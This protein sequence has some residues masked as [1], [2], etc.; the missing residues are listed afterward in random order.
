MIPSRENFYARNSNFPDGPENLLDCSKLSSPGA[1]RDWFGC[2]EIFSRSRSNFYSESLSGFSLQSFDT[3]GF[4]TN[5]FG[6]AG[7]EIEF[8]SAS[9][10]FSLR[11]KT[12][13]A[14]ACVVSLLSPLSLKMII[15]HFAG[16]ESPSLAPTFN[17]INELQ[18]TWGDTSRGL[19]E[20][21]T[22]VVAVA[23]VAATVVTA[24]TLA[25]VTAAAVA[26]GTATLTAGGA[27]VVGVSVSSA[28]ASTLSVSATNTSMNT[29]GSLFAQ[30]KDITKTAA[31][32][33]TSDEA[34]KNYAIA[35][36][37]AGLTFGISQGINAI[38]NASN[39]ANTTNAA[40][41]VNTANTAANSL[42]ATQRVTNSI[43]NSLIQSVSS[44]V[45][46]STINGDSF[47][48]SLNNSMQNLLINAVGEVAANE[49]GTAAHGSTVV[50]ESGQIIGTT[51]ATISKAEQLALHAALGCGMA[52][53]GGNN[54]AAGAASGMAG[55]EFAALLGRNTNF[56]KS[57]IIE[58]SKLA[59]ALTSASIV[60][61]GDGDSVFAGSQIARNA[62]ENNATYFSNKKI[63]NYPK[64]KDYDLNIGTQYSL[65]PVTISHGTD[66]ND[67]T[68]NTLPS[69][70]VGG[71]VNYVPRGEI[72]IVGANFGIKDMITI[73]SIATNKGNFGFGLTGGFSIAPPIPFNTSISLGFSN[74][75]DQKK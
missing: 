25:P 60:G 35:G 61:A 7:G 1:D 52:A 32:D 4:S 13:H 24:G 50:N 36:A 66:G 34:L 15:D 69:I 51:V 65:G 22:A 12:T 40:N 8:V 54:C 28:A 29:D 56:T 63:S 27:F 19:T 48:E 23:A 72:P 59:G 74:G 62:A 6:F 14:G 70:A 41:G 39:A 55:E 45:A 58:S 31:K 18:Q 9:S 43:Q 53:A 16:D 44:S 20:A 57:Q 38:G 47:T 11:S 42:T 73:D 33:T 10:L 17:K 64:G 71:Y 30:T 68:I 26:G 37:A 75:E 49:I 21:G 46:Q 2:L 67:A 3:P 5:E